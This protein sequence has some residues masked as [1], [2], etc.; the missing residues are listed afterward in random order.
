MVHGQS[1]RL[2]CREDGGKSAARRAATKGIEPR[3]SRIGKAPT[4][5][6]VLDRMNRMDRNPKEQNDDGLRF[7]CSGNIKPHRP[8]EITQ[9]QINCEAGWDGESR[10]TGSRYLQTA[11]IRLDRR[12]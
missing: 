9:P 10:L 5:K 8:A 7:C 2:N 12:R 4:K 1:F 3:I 6:D 11:A